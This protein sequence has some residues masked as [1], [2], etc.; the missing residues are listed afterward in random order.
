MCRTMPLHAVQSEPLCINLLLDTAADTPTLLGD[1][2]GSKGGFGLKPTF[3]L[4]YTLFLV[5]PLFHC[6]WQAIAAVLV[7]YLNWRPLAAPPE[8]MSGIELPE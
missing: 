4:I 7:L 8:Y 6:L 2:G 3:R 1:Q 5:S